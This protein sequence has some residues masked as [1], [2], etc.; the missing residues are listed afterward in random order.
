MNKLLSLFVFVFII[1]CNNSAKKPIPKKGEIQGLFSFERV[2]ELKKRCIENGDAEAFRNLV[3]HY[4]KTS[5]DYELLPIAL[6]MADR[7]NSGHARSTIYFC[8]LEIQNQGRDEK[9]FFKLDKI[10]QDFILKYLMD[11][12]K[13]KDPGCLGIS[14]RLIKNGL[15]IEKKL[16]LNIEAEYKNLH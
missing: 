7:H 16:E 12:V 6:I 3:S 5:E 11:G 2:A 13:I 10:K 1:S 15:K 14:H 9:K 4:C 8:F